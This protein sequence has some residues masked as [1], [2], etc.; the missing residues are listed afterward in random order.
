[1]GV[2][3]KFQDHSD[4][5]TDAV[6]RTSSNAVSSLGREKLFTG[7]SALRSSIGQ[8]WLTALVSHIT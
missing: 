5:P 6:C 1:M 8:G 2:N 7:K 3:N 4:T